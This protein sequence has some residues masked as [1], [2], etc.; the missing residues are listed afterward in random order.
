MPETQRHPL[1]NGSS[2]T[3][4]VNGLHQYW[5]DG[6]PVKRP[7]VTGLAG[8][9]DSDAFGAGMGYAIKLAELTGNPK[10]A[11]QQSSIDRKAG[12]EF[13]ASVN[14]F[15]THGSIS[16]DPIFMCWYNEVGVD[17]DW[18]A[19]ETLVYHPTLKYGGTA[20]AISLE[21]P[22]H[23]LPSTDGKIKTVLWDWKTVGRASWETRG[24]SLRWIKDHAQVSGYAKA[25]RAM[26]SIYE[27]EAAF[28]CY[29][30][31]D[32]S[33][34]VTQEVDLASGERVFDASRAMY[35]LRRE[36]ANGK[37]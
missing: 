25:L 34:T 36:V 28:I 12:E 2:L 24:S 37:A 17:R 32:G 13:H 7:S 26:G 16:E 15:I 8:F 19:S 1:K 33:Y 22:A 35:M 20:D 31:R 4:H 27:I 10:E 29:I 5:T 23:G 11:R 30:M 18:L 9:T 6:D 3:V 14:E 21:T